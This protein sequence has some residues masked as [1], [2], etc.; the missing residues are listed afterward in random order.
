MYIKYEKI[1]PYNRYDIDA[2]TH[3]GVVVTQLLLMQ[4]SGSHVIWSK[5]VCHQA[6]NWCSLGWRY[7]FFAHRTNP[8]PP[9]SVQCFGTEWLRVTGYKQLRP[10]RNYEKPALV[11]CFLKKNSHEVETDQLCN[12]S[13]HSFHPNWWL[14]SWKY[15]IGGSGDG[16]YKQTF[17]YLKKFW[18]IFL[19]VNHSRPNLI[20]YHLES[21]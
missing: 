10:P 1:V 8:P 13:S 15:S 14:V 4:K 11:S 9:Q 12:Q 18:Y 5:S 7:S 3:G 21:L 2:K 6:A 17:I 19:F 16:R 20:V